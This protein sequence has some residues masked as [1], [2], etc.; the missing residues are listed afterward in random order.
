MTLTVDAIYEG[1]TLKLDKPLP[2]Q[3]HQKV[4]VTI[5]SEASPLLQAYG[6]MGW[7]GDAETIERIA[8]DSEFLPEEAP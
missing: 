1:G 4:R 3:E 8:R 7:T 5:Q 6:I 2:L